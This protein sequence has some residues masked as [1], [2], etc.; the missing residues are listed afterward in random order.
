MNTFFTKS[1]I[2]IL[3]FFSKFLIA[4]E[5]EGHLIKIN[6]KGLQEGKMCILANYYGDKQYIKDSAKVDAKGEVIFKGTEKYPQG[7]YMFIL[8]TK[9]YFDFIMDAKQQFSL[10][11]DTVDLIKNMKVKNSDENKYFYE[12]QNFMGIKQDQIQPLR[13]E[14]PKLKDKDSIKTIKDKI[15]KIDSEVLNYKETFIKNNPNTFIA[16]LFNAMEEPKIPD[17]PL[18]A[19]GAKDTLFP[20]RYYKAHFFD[21]VDFNDERMLY[22]PLFHK[23]I[24]QY[25]DNLT[26]QTPD[27]I[28]VSAD[29]LIKK[30]KVNKEVFKYL[31]YWLT[32]TYES[33]PIMGMDA[34]FVHLVNKYYATKQA[35]WVDS[36]QLD[37]ITTRANTLA[38]ILIGKKAP[39][40]NMADS[41]GKNIALYDVKA[42]YTIVLFWEH[43]CGHCKTAVPKLL[44]LYE[45][46]LR[47]QGVAVYA[48]EIDDKPIEW[49]KF[50][51]ENKLNWI[52][53]HEMDAYKRAVAKK[54]YDIASTPI[55]YVLDKD[56]TIIAKRLDVD[57][58]EGLIDFMEKRDQPNNEK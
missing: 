51:V 50:I 18:L 39:A 21:N 3:F 15:T 13:E 52:N 1:I 35:Y 6:V 10:A 45:S 37:K 23:K 11:T 57:Q 2:V 27:S 5:P 34:V 36:T 24:K 41:T 16:K 4:S 40:L 56:K 46:K 43:T 47:S 29:Y 28:N 20:Y 17:A 31:V 9:K 42:K 14:L 25:M 44:S 58:I 8:P 19:N 53:V 30:G 22:T 26:A 33:S 38:P 32:Y 55:I 12:F 48:I 7:V 54:M 49:K